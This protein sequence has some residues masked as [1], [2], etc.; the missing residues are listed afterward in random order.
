MGDF[1]GLTPILLY[2]YFSLAFME[3]GKKLSDPMYNIAW[4]PAIGPALIAYRTTERI[5]WP[6]LFLPATFIFLV[7]PETLPIAFISFLVF[8]LCL[9]DWYR[10]MFIKLGKPG[11]WAFLL[12]IPLVNLVIIGIAAWKD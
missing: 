1:A 8:G 2:I 12:L 3:I 4:I 10:K 5:W 11:W 6:W 7:S 9:L